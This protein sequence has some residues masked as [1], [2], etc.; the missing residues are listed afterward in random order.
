VR[1]GDAHAYRRQVDA[2]R[3]VVAES[4][5]KIA[6]ASLPDE[7]DQKLIADLITRLG[8]RA[9]ADADAVAKRVKAESDA[10]LASIKADADAALTSAKK[11]LQAASAESE[12]RRQKLEQ[13]AAELKS[14]SGELANLTNARD[15][16]EAA[17]KRA[18]S[19]AEDH[20]AALAAA[21]SEA[22]EATSALSSAR[23]ELEGI[24][25]QL[26]TEAA[27]RAK[28]AAA[29]TAAQA[30][31]QAA[32]N[33]RKSL[34][35]RLNAAGARVK[36]LER[37]AA[38]QDDEP[39][40]ELQAR[41]DRA[42]ATEAQ[43]RQ[44]LADALKAL[45]QARAQPPPAASVATR[46]AAADTAARAREALVQPLDRLLEAHQKMGQ[47]RTV[48]GILTVL[49]ESVAEE[50]ARVAL[51]RVHENHL[52]GVKQIGLD[53]RGDVSSLVVPFTRDSLLTRVVKTREIEQFT[54][55]D[56]VE[57]ERALFGGTPAYGVVMPVTVQDHMLAVLYADNPRPHDPVQ[58][59]RK[60]K[61]AQLLLAEATPLLPDLLAEERALASL[62]EYART[63]I[64]QI[65]RL[66]AADCER[67]SKETVVLTRLRE[68]VQYARQVF[69]ERA[70][71]APEAAADLL[72]RHIASAANAEGGTAFARALAAALGGRKR[73]E[74]SGQKHAAGHTRRLP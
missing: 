48:S 10:A 74:K 21:R 59:V 8:A 52:A 58:I 45:Q 4:F 9:A 30:Q 69:A 65:A 44:E 38:E 31:L 34:L 5:E 17:R 25:R 23:A 68:H 35:E 56:A 64:K 49:V 32:E 73:A 12:R 72:D 55:S 18:E 57:S 29:W 61:T 15:R 24:T 6:A 16:A 27:E 7:G 3:K 51:F 43:L 37:S 50:F 62:D 66:Y 42:A 2:L 63:L 47:H 28:I 60:A 11:E 46:Q 53:F 41:L 19:L 67:G 40:R 36:T 39:R 26:E 20:A 1:A 22:D 13:L 14:V 71:R 70:E 54:S 33:E